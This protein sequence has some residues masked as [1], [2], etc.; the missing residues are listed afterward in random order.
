MEFTKV[1]KHEI[2]G[3]Y[4]NVTYGDLNLNG[5][6][7]PSRYN[8][9]ERSIDTEETIS[10]TDELNGLPEGISMNDYFNMALLQRLDSI[11]KNIKGLQNVSV[12]IT[13]DN[14]SNELLVKLASLICGESVKIK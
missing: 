6:Y 11:E 9:E 13:L 12:N 3:V 5:E 1:I 14:I 10:Q 2:S 7:Y 8:S 4:G